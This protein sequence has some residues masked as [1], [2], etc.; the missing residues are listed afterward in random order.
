[1]TLSIICHG[2]AALV[3]GAA[4]SFPEQIKEG[5]GAGG[6]AM[7]AA[8]ELTLVSLALG[9]MFWHR[10]RGT[11]H[12]WLECRFAAEIL[13][14]VAATAGIL[15]PLYP[16]IKR[17]L[18]EW[19][20]LALSAML[21]ASR[22]GGAGGSLETLRER[23][24][25]GRI[26][27]QER[28]FRERLKRAAPWARFF[29]R[30]ASVTAVGAV[31]VVF[32]ALLYKLMA[33]GNSHPPL[34][35]TLVVY[36]LPIALPLLAGMASSLHNALDVGRRKVRYAGMIDNLAQARAW[37]EQLDTLPNL[38]RAVSRAEEVLLDEQIEWLAAAEGGQGH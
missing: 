21:P 34:L 24:L 29:N 10:R 17:H 4:V 6:L 23:Y 31:L 22:E 38:R 19:R 9:L 16:Q 28:Y 26:A 20:R 35:L 32:S 5:I 36:F 14:G 7:L 33:S 2:I 37:I 13:R 11:Q 15:D 1:M 27:D 8:L 12:K 3:A 30:C 25:S 18:P